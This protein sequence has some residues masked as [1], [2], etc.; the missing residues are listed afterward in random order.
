[1]LLFLSD[2]KSLLL[3]LSTVGALMNFV[4]WCAAL[5]CLISPDMLQ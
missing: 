4:V 3:M 2:L 1:L 5:C